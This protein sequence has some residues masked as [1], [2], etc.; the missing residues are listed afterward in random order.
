[1]SPVSRKK[2]LLPF[3]HG[4]LEG[5]SLGKHILQAAPKD[6]P[7]Q[8]SGVILTHSKCGTEWGGS[9]STVEVCQQSI[10]IVWVKC[11]YMGTMQLNV[12]KHTMAA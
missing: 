6:G 11:R 2:R 10:P 3:P 9:A 12:A 5:P 1:M 7:N 8:N 4:K